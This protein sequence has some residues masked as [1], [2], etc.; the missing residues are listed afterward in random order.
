MEDTND[1]AG[2]NIQDVVPTQ[3][4][5]ADADER[6]PDKDGEPQYEVDGLDEAEDGGDHDRPGGVPRREAELV[7]HLDCGKLIINIV[8]RSAT[9][10]ECFKNCHHDDVEDESDKEV[11]EECCSAGVESSN[12]DKQ[13]GYSMTANFQMFQ[14]TS[15]CLAWVLVVNKLHEIFAQFDVRLQNTLQS[16]GNFSLV[17][18]HFP[19]WGPVWS[20]SAETCNDKTDSLSSNAGTEL[21]GL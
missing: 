7:H 4:D 17:L 21:R 3:D 11:E 16:R 9:P 1:D 10:G 13:P 5:S 15:Q 14:V 2:N 6:G 18:R 8:G 19:V 12:G 20:D